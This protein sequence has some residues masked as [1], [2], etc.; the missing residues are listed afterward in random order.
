MGLSSEKMDTPAGALSGGERARL[1]LGLVTFDGPHL[2]ILD[3]PTNHLDIDSREELM[4]ALNAY[5][6][7][8][9]VISH[10]RH[11][12]EASAERLWLVNNGTVA[13]Y[14]GD[15]EDYKRLILKG[16]D[17]PEKSKP[18]SKPRLPAGETVE[19][20]PKLN[21]KEA[22][23]RIRQL[24]GIM[25]KAEEAIIKLDDR[26]A[27]A[28]MANEVERIRQLSEKRTEFERRL[29]NVEQ[30]WLSLSEAV[31]TGGASS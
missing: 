11:L 14:D 28:S 4:M 19:A 1:L 6:G 21:V 13:P 29:Q 18:E 23:K 31:E 12:V 26:L 8:V 20:D 17:A 3:E 5:Q 27:D 15:M 25:E 7:A 2:L 9:I 16:S 22:R 10:D 24:E 30:E